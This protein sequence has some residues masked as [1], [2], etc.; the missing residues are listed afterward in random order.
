MNI[1]NKRYEN[2]EKASQASGTSGDSGYHA[3]VKHTVS[4]EGMLAVSQN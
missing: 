3:K 4:L 1:R 2:F